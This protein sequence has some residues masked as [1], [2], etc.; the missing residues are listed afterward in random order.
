MWVLRMD[1]KQRV[2]GSQWFRTVKW[3]VYTEFSEGKGRVYGGGKTFTIIDS[4]VGVVSERRRP[5]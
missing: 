4:G 3:K 1:Q 2:L 5:G